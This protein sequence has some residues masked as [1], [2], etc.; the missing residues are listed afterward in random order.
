MIK[1]FETRPIHCT[2][3]YLIRSLTEHPDLAQYIDPPGTT[4]EAALAEL[5]KRNPTDLVPCT[6]PDCTECRPRKR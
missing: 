3:A 1:R 5:R 4:A 6:D 2:V